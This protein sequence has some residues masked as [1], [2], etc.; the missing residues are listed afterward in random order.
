MRSIIIFPLYTV[1]IHRFG[2]SE[3]QVG[4]G[5]VIE[6]D[7]MNAFDPNALIVRDRSGGQPIAYIRR[8][9]AARLTPLLTTIPY[10]GRVLLKPKFHMEICNRR[11]RQVCTVGFR[12]SD[13]ESDRA[14][15]A[16]QESGLPYKVLWFVCNLIHRV[17]GTFF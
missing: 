16:L 5:Y 10:N 3:L 17:A 15:E 2:R 14:I 4:W 9:D 11:P 6:R 13:T 1:S 12:V 7:A 8:Q